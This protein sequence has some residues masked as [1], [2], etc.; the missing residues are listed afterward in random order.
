ME[1]MD[2]ES[3][4]GGSD[5]G[6]EQVSRS[7][8]ELGVIGGSGVSN[9]NA[10]EDVEFHEVQTPFG[11]PSTKLTLGALGGRTVAFLKRH[12]DCHTL[13]PSEVNYRANIFALKMLGVKRIISLSAVG[14]LKERFRPGEFVIPS[15]FF[16]H[17]RRRSDTFF[18]AGVVAHVGLADPVCS[19]VGD[20][21]E[22]ACHDVGVK[23]HRG[24]TY[25]CIEGPHFSTRA[26][27]NV[28]RSWGM[29]VV[30]M[31]NVQ[32]AKL[33]REAGICYA[34]L[35]MVTDYDCWRDRDSAVTV[36][37]ALAVLRQN[38]ANATK[39]TEAAIQ[40]MPEPTCQCS[41]ALRTA[42]VTDSGA[43]TPDN[44]E[45]IRVLSGTAPARV[46]A[47]QAR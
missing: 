14:S 23:A 8:V 27:S 26:E 18:G 42:L 38:A 13:L 33:A 19:E 25:L 41:E 9:L 32:E 4:P 34:T 7:S 22:S 45:L 24:G 6:T 2:A 20:A 43:L 17:T 36:E 31:T 11:S 46:R 40:S 3:G 29:D 15:Q 37:Q 1:L 5:I 44:R 39:V 47:V 30:G 21:L 28:Y 16:D 35:A 10:L 12:G